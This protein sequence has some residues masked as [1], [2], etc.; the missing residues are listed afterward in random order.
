[1]KRASKNFYAI[2]WYTGECEVGGTYYDTYR[3]Q[4]RRS[5]MWTNVHG[6]YYIT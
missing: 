2:N 6:Y 5:G 4:M 3:I 1:M